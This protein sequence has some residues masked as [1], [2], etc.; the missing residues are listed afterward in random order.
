MAESDSFEVQE[1]PSARCVAQARKLDRKFCCTRMTAI[2]SAGGYH[3]AALTSAGRLVAFGNN[4]SGQTSVPAL[5]DGETYTEVSA[6]YYHTAALK[7][8]FYASPFLPSLVSSH[9]GYDRNAAS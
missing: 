2:I 1:V 6:G 9:L 8:R 4:G 3:T 7:S 5:K